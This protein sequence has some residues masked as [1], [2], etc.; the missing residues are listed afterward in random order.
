MSLPPFPA[1][2]DSWR[3]PLDYTEGDILRA[4]ENETAHHHWS[5]DAAEAG[6]T[7]ADTTEVQAGGTCE[8]WRLWEGWEKGG[9]VLSVALT[10]LQPVLRLGIAVGSEMWASG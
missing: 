7:N 4:S 10:H 3:V 1:S 5:P 9:C 6:L 2:M 8:G